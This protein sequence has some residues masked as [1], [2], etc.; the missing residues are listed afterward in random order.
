MLQGFCGKILEPTLEFLYESTTYF[1]VN[2]FKVNV[3]NINQGGNAGS[4]SLMGK[5]STFFFCYVTENDL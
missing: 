3:Q 1:G 5:E 4:R 2:G